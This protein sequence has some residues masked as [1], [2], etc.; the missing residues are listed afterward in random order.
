MYELYELAILYGYERYGNIL[1]II[2]ISN[3]I[4]YMK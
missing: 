4:S 3:A 1:V 2:Y